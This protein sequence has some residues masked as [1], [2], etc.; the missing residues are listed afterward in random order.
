[1][2][3]RR[4]Q[5]ARTHIL[6]HLGALEVRTVTRDDVKRLVLALDAKTR[7]GFTVSPDGTRKPFAWKTALNAWSVVRALFRDAQRAKALDLCVRA[8]NPS[9]GVAG[10]DRGPTKAKAY[11]WPSEFVTLVTCPR[12]TVRWR[13]LVAVA[14]YTYLRPG[15]LAALDCDD[16]DLEHRVLHIHCAVDRVRGGPPKATK[17][18]R[19]RR[20]PIELAAQP[21]LQALFLEAGGRGPLFPM[22]SVA[23]SRPSSR[24][25]CASPASRAPICS[26]ATLPAGRSPSTICARPG[27]PGWPSAATDVH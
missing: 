26:R 22:P 27:S 24:R 13:R 23:S 18:G 8:D 6:P 4:S 25:T 1:M 20:I 12:V 15:E 16:V 5:A 19:A 2:R 17:T 10:P 21:L 3:D 11:L 7:Q 14:V 9:E